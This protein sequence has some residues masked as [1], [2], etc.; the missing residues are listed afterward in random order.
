MTVLETLNAAS[1]ELADAVLDVTHAKHTAQLAEQIPGGELDRRD[2]RDDVR[3]DVEKALRRLRSVETALVD[4]LA[5]K[6]P[7]AFD[8]C[9]CPEDVKGTGLAAM[10]CQLHSP[11]KDPSR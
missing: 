5:N 6:L 3:I 8:P 9:A 4:M 10:N 7:G 11:F 2:R 1:T